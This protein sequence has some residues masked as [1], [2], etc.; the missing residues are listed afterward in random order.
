MPAAPGR[1]SSRRCRRTAATCPPPPAGAGG[2]ADHQV[3]GLALLLLLLLLLRLLPP[4]ARDA[5]RADGACEDAQ[6]GF[7][8]AFDSGMVRE[9]CNQ[10]YLS[11]NHKCCPSGAP[12]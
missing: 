5:H 1:C 6:K 4:R 2:R 10:K 9:P 12:G 3:A 8:P 11:R 7:A